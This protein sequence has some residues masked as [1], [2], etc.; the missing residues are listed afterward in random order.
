MGSG[1]KQI[2]PTE[3]M[4]L[5]MQQ[6]AYMLQRTYK[7]EKLSSVTW[8]KGPGGGILPK[9]I[10]LIIGRKV[11]NDIKKDTAINWNDV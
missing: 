4:T 1:I 6:N 8:L 11:N 3:L 9:Y 10:D 2:Q 7:K 5:N